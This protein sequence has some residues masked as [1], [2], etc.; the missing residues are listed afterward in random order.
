M[1]Q[2]TAAP[3]TVDEHDH[4]LDDDDDLDMDEDLLDDSVM[5]DFERRDTDDF[6]F[7]GFTYTDD[8]FLVSSLGG[9]AN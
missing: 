3:T 2:A 8:D 1:L 7:D 9:N 4:D 6:H 5:E